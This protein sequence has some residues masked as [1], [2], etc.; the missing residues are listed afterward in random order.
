MK[1]EIDISKVSRQLL[2]I[3]SFFAGDFAIKGP[4]FD[5]TDSS[6][7]GPAKQLAAVAADAEPCADH[8]LGSLI[9]ALRVVTPGAPERAAFE[10]DRGSDPRT[11]VDGAPL[12]V[13][14]LP[15]D[16]SHRF[17]NYRCGHAH[18]REDTSLQALY[19]V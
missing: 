1:K 16:R 12:E 11:V 19:L 6:T 8:Q 2:E 9:H 15:S 13:E 4:R 7:D 18:H 5:F 10:K 17:Q 3:D 14:D